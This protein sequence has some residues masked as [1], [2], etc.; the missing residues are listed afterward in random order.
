MQTF[1]EEFA[2]QGARLIAVQTV[3]VEFILNYPAPATQVTQD[4]LRHTLAQ[5]VRFIAAFEA[6][7]QADGRMQA[8]VECRPLIGQM[9]KRPWW[10]WRGAQFGAPGI[11][12]W[13]GI[14][15]CRPKGS[16]VFRVDQFQPRLS[17]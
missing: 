13:P 11:G 3:Q 14:G 17:R 4:A 5:V 10:R 9:L 16:E 6:V 7:L 12:Q 2:E 15:H 8:I 1:S